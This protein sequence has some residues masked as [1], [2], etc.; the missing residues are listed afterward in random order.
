MD[1]EE[2]KAQLSAYI[3]N[4]VTAEEAALIREHISICPDCEQEEQLLR[5]T[6]ELLENWRDVPAPDGFCEALLAKAED[7]SHQPRRIIAHAIRPW[8][9]PRAFIKATFSGAAILFLCL[10]VIFFSRL[11]SRK[12]TIIEP[13]PTKIESVSQKMDDTIQTSDD[14]P[15]YTTMAEI[16]IAG[17]W[18]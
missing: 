7:I 3:D 15:I 11:S 12:P 18:E 17:M 8:A 13:L 1:C 6:S 5:R 10:G 2:V 14:L 4:E 16:K 9:F